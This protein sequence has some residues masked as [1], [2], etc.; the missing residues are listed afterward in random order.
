MSLFL[1]FYL[2]A[3]AIVAAVAG[4]DV[5]LAVHS[6]EPFG[7]GA[8]KVYALSAFVCYPV[9]R[10]VVLSRPPKAENELPGH[11]VTPEQQPALWARVREL[12]GLTGTRGPQELRLIPSANAGVVERSALLGLGRGHRTMLI[13]APLLIGL[14]ERE[15]DAVLAHEL[16]HYGHQDTRLAVLTCT[17]RRSIQHT[18][19][20]LRDQPDGDRRHAVLARVFGAYATLYN[21]VSESVSRRQEYAADLAAARIAGRDAT[22]SALRRI[23]ALDATHGLYLQ[24]YALVGWDH[25]LLPQR[26]E[27]FGGFARLLADPQRR[28]ELA[29]LCRRLPEPEP[30]PYDSHPPIAERVAAIEALAPDGR[31]ADASGPALALLI[32][33]EEPLG[34]LERAVLGAESDTME[35]LDWPA[36]I[37]RNG[38]A[39]Y[40]HH[41]EQLRRAADCDEL[42]RALAVVLESAADGRLWQLADRLPKSEQAQA[43]TGRAAREF[44]RQQLRRA[45]ADLCHLNLA[46]AGLARWELSWAG[47][48]TSTIPDGLPQA[49]GPALDALVADA[50]DPRPLRALLA[51][52]GLELPLPAGASALPR[53]DSL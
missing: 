2:L 41:A 44:A 15:L 46:D 12:A 47:P 38:R 49:L 43:A 34:E 7:L 10:V 6:S 36:L 50:T 25:G 32:R 18:V 17:A 11:P 21:T 51:S 48:P 39:R 20:T 53:A 9:L 13:G 3:A 45:V 5:V 31:R 26:G 22:A 4:L 16:G 28:E 8:F 40:A 19:R 14:T 30:D 27:V 23:A 35:R 37:H 1:G 33:P 29:E 52:T 42:P 24:R